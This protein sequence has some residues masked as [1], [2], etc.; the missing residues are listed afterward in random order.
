MKRLM[1]NDLFVY[2]SKEGRSYDFK[3]IWIAMLSSEYGF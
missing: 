1:I 2:I 3:L